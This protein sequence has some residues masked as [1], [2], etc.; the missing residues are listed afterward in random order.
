MSIYVFAILGY[1]VLF[2]T[3]IVLIRSLFSY[4]RKKI[5]SRDNN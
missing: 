3:A 4:F 1:I 5:T 2:L